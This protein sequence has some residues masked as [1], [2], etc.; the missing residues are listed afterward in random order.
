MNENSSD[1]S[2]SNFSKWEDID[3]PKFKDLDIADFKND[4]RFYKIDTISFDEEYPRREAFENIIAS[5]NNSEK[6]ISTHKTHPN[7]TPSISK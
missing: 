4:V 3:H 6:W 7:F 2:F 5:V 1:L